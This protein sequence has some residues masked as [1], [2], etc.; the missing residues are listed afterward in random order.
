MKNSPKNILLSHSSNDLYG[1]SKVLITTI[2]VLILNG[3][4]VHLILPSNGPLNDHKTIKKVHLSILDLGVFRRKYFTFWGLLNRLFYIVKSAIFLKKYIKK[5]K[6]DVVFINTSTII[7]P[8]ISSFLLKIPTVY[9]IHEIPFG[10]PVYL[11]FITAFLN[12]FSREIICV[13]KS[14]KDYWI[15]NG[16]IE[17]KISVI[18]NG[19]NF[20]FNL[21]KKYLNHKIIFTSISRIIPYKGHAFLIDLFKEIIKNRNDVILQIVGNTLPQY[22][23][24]LNDL[25]LKVKEYQI[26]KNIFFLGFIPNINSALKK[27]NFFIHVPIEPD[28]APA[29]I[30]E[31]IESKTPV[32]YSDNGG[33]KELLDNGRNGLEIDINDSKK[34]SELILNYIEENDLHEKR[35]NDSINFISKT[36]TL[37]QYKLK[38]I[39]LLKKY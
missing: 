1:A 36:F 7:S 6:I 32:I 34:S 38:L 4:N 16:L 33:A 18:Y 26:D 17:K 14:V 3:F 37:D 9:H 10:N 23:T 28:P 27:S 11:R 5:N 35:I 15:K 29:V 19:Y 24:Y 25:K 12:I 31:A 22:H 13:S 8:C 2:E 20:D 39:N 21:K 30:L